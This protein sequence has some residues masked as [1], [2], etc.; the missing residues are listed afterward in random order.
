M[1]WYHVFG[2]FMAALSITG[3][4]FTS[5]PVPVQTVTIP[6][7][8][9]KNPRG[10]L[11]LFLP[12]ALHVGDEAVVS[13]QIDFPFVQA[14]EVEL[15]KIE[16]SSRLEIG[17]IELSPKGEGHVLVDPDKSSNFTWRIRPARV[18]NYSGRLWLFSKETGQETSLI[19]ARE[20][21][22]D[23]KSFLGMSYR[24]T[25]MTSIFGAAIGLILFSPHVIRSIKKKKLA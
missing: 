14:N 16:L 8:E 9:G 23:S 4:F 17:M 21:S 19:L 20:I 15:R 10:I 5:W 1:R 25:R 11:T 22:L 3:I 18:G 6:F 13:L 7:S 12:E 2:L 24:I